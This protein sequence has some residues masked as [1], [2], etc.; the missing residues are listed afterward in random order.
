[1]EQLKLTSDK[2]TYS[3]IVDSVVVGPANVKAADIERI[4]GI[5]VEFFNKSKKKRNDLI[6]GGSN[7]SWTQKDET[8]MISKVWN[9]PKPRTSRIQSLPTSSSNQLF[10]VYGK[11]KAQMEYRNTKRTPSMASSDLYHQFELFSKFG[12]S[13]SSG[14]QITL[15]Q[16]DKW[17]RQAKVIDS[18]NVTTTDTAIA[19]RKISRGSI[20]LDYLA[21]R[22][23]LEEFTSRARLDFQDVVDRLEMCGIPSLTESTRLTANFSY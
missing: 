21:W 11:R 15:S 10:H 18:W 3:K 6:E 23:F 1:L 5:N 4:L 7:P 14:S 8:S 16:S 20:W 2:E 12:G 22:E 17:L 19:F 9:D 13:G